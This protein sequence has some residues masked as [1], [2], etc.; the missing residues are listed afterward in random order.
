MLRGRRRDEGMRKWGNEGMGND[1]ASGSFCLPRPSVSFPHSLIPSFPRHSAFLIAFSRSWSPRR[2]CRPPFP[3]CPA[4]RRTTSPA[5]PTCPVASPFASQSCTP[6]TPYLA[7]WSFTRLTLWFT[8]HRRPRRTSPCRGTSP[9]RLL[10]RRE[11][12]AHSSRTTSPRTRPPPAAP[13]RSPSRGR[14]ACRRAS[15]PPRRERRV[16]TSNP[17]VL[18]RGH[19]RPAHHATV[20]A[21][22]TAAARKSKSVISAVVPS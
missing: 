5:R 3:P 18:R 2:R 9:P 4:R 11:Q 1:T 10:Q 16:P 19:A 12:R 22:A 7:T 13:S 8:D 15:A 21:G 6:G 17:P 20:S 14:S